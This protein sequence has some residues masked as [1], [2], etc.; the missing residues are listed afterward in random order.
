MAETR[1]RVIAVA[2]FWYLLSVLGPRSGP[3]GFEKFNKWATKR[4]T[5]WQL[6]LLTLVGYYIAR[7]IDAILNLHPKMARHKIYES[8][9]ETAVTVMTACNAGFMTA[10]SIR[11]KLFRDFA[12]LIFTVYYIFTPDH[13]FEKV[14]K[15]NENPSVEGIRT[16]FEIMANPYLNCV[17]NLLR[18]KL[19]GAQG[20]K[21]T[22]PRPK[23]SFYLAPVTMTL[24]YDKPLSCLK[25]ERKIIF[26]IHGGGFISNYPHLH[27]DSL[28]AWAKQTQLPIFAINYKLAPEYPFPYAIDECFDAYTAIVESR[29]LCLGIKSRLPPRVVF[30]GDSAGGNFSAVL[31]I[32]II[33][34]RNKALRDPAV[35]LVLTYPALD[36]SPIG[37][38]GEK[39]MDYFRQEAEEDQNMM[40]FETKKEVVELYKSGVDPVS[41]KNL[42]V[43]GAPGWEDVDHEQPLSMSSRVLFMSDRVI[44]AE[45]LY[46][47]VLMYIG[48]DRGTDFRG[49]PLVSPLW[50]KDSILAEFPRCF[51]TCGTCDPLCDDTVIFTSRLR[52]ARRAVDPKLDIREDIIKTELLKGVSHGFLQF[53]TVYPKTAGI[54]KKIGSWFLE[55]FEKADRDTAAGVGRTPLTREE[56]QMHL[57]K[58]DVETSRYTNPFPGY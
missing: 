39:E 56:Y 28:T 52:N 1:S 2:L 21:F 36:L 51:V 32:K 9:F 53:D 5:A 3:P 40:M 54:Y 38:F 11:P 10:K 23:S 45:G 12:S 13:A 24:W 43:A 55:A 20:T 25:N 49:D 41:L 44:P 50:A 57:A 7:N 48:T 34:A 27:A 19:K 29:G 46:V 42:V 22:I 37:F 4:F 35:G 16:S 30:T 8:Q 6:S 18:P 33:M 26:H 15:F 47:M 17:G 31:M 14:R 58:L